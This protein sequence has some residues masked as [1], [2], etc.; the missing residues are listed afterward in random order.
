MD[1]NGERMIPAPQQTVWDAL[2][3]PTVL[4]EC[5]PGC[6]QM[7]KISE[8]EY[9]LGMLA[10]VGPVKARF[11]GKLLLSDITA[12][13]CYALNFEGS[14][15]AAGFGKGNAHVTL[16]PANGG[17]TQLE[18]KATAQVGGKLAQVGSRLIDGIARK[19][20]EDFFA[21]F[22]ALVTA[23]E[24]ASNPAEPSAAVSMPPVASESSPMTSIQTPR[25]AI[26]WS[27]IALLAVVVLA[28]LALIYVP[29]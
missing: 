3:D 6:D 8:T 28:V 2:N 4:Q 13:Q 23:A 12:P 22:E 16:S 29:R 11:A 17:A 14:G 24:A 21:K 26:S 7:E 18:Y 9:R 5:I 27:M 1:I 19:I 20:A 15:G 10:I 25:R